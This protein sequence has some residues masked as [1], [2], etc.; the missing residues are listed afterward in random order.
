L[1]SVFSQVGAFALT[2]GS[3][4]AALL[5]NLAPGQYSIHVEGADGETGVALAELYDADQG[6]VTS[7]LINISASATVGTGANVLIAGFVISGT[8]SETVL[9]RGVGP[10][11]ASLGVSNV[12]Q[13]PVLTLFDKNSNPLTSNTGW[14][15]SSLIAAASS[16]VYAFALEPNSA[17]S[18]LLV[19][20]APG[21]YSIG[22]SG[23]N[24]TSGEALVEVYEVR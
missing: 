5:E 18:A 20:L 3:A 11:L 17:D 6:T 15:N 22:V 12:L 13:Q 9:L 7:R 8:T 23:A 14:A 4:D 2:R 19:T 1:A 24:S 16:A 21:L 10:T